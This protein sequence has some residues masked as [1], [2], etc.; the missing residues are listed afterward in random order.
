MQKRVFQDVTLEMFEMG[1]RKWEFEWE[2]IGDYFHDSKILQNMEISNLH[3]IRLYR[4]FV[5]ELINFK[6]KKL[7]ALKMNT[8]ISQRKQNWKLDNHNYNILAFSI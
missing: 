3:K 5:Y 7:K 2:R 8:S 4:Q 6:A 1:R